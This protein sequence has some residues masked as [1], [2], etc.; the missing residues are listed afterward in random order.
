MTADLNNLETLHRHPEAKVA[1]QRL[2]ELEAQ[3]H[4]RLIED[5]SAAEAKLS[6]ILNNL[7][8]IVLEIEID[9]KILFANRAWNEHLGYAIADTNG[10][11]LQDFI[12]D[13]DRG[14]TGEFDWRQFGLG[15]E[16]QCRTL[17]G[18][19]IWVVIEFRPLDEDHLTVSIRN[20]QASKDSEHRQ[21]DLEENLRSARVGLDKT[22]EELTASHS[23]VELLM[24]AAPVGLALLDHDQRIRRA[25]LSF[26]ELVSCAEHELQGQ[27]LLQKFGLSAQ[28][29]SDRLDHVRRTGAQ[30]HVQI[31]SS[32]FPWLRDDD[33]TF[34]LH[35][36]PIPTPTHD[37]CD[38]GIIIQ[39]ISSHVAM[40]KSLRRSEERFRKLVELIPQFVWITD[41]RGAIRYANSRWQKYVGD[42][43]PLPTLGASIHPE[44][45][46]DYSK[47]WVSDGPAGQPNGIEM[48]VR[49]QGGGYRW[50]LVQAVPVLSERGETSEWFVTGT[51]IQVQKD[52][53]AALQ[54][55]DRRKDEFLAVL[56]HELRN[57]LAPMRNALRILQ[58]EK[59]NPSDFEWSLGLLGRQLTKLSRHLDDLVDI[60]SV[61]Q[62]K[63][64]LKMQVIDVAIAV[65]HAVETVQPLLDARR[66]T[67]HISLPPEPACFVVDHLRFEQILVNLLGN[68]SKYTSPQG[69]IEIHVRADLNEI[70]IRVVDDGIGISESYFPYL[71]RLF[72]QQSDLSNPQVKDGLGIGLFLTK[73][74]VEMHGGR[75][76]AASPGRGQGSCFTVHLPRRME[77]T[78]NESRAEP[79]TFDSPSAPA[80]IVVVDDYPGSAESMAAVLKSFGHLVHTA[81][82]GKSALEAASQFLPD[83]VLLDL[84]LPDING[85]EVARRLR[86]SPH[87]KHLLLIAVTG[88]GE[89]RNRE[90][91]KT[92]GFDL[93]V[94]KPVEDEL[95]S[96]ILGLLDR[97]GGKSTVN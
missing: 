22:R 11:K 52:F 80:R 23:L 93:H 72:S 96:E 57:P 30:S 25:N 36:F 5:L 8:E 76:H 69:N 34:L 73:S 2:F 43:L 61:R 9:G 71:F 79:V 65:R 20:I 63:L 46:A 40:E 81:F 62:H 33:R 45:S 95:L 87:G 60:A 1:G 4:Y 67:L 16:I 91:S 84:G 38:L 68:S 37:R 44:D 18:S 70:C 31:S 24:Q 55:A 78:K 58:L 35:F 66:Q 88:W 85:Y 90:M 15:K 50:F 12:V 94:R 86:S 48:R 83:M 7:S 75:I 14:L 19:T 13:P 64:R 47:L 89:D 97:H 28:W 51:D 39:D 27:T 56:A 74:L 54:D 41:S 53:N 42:W 82:D 3:T 26:A 6:R 10:R 29:I 59:L 21:K 77:C 17:N 32:N 49:D 92:A